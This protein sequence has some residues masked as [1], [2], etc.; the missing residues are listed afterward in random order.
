MAKP[1]LDAEKRRLDEGADLALP[2]DHHAQ[3]T[4]HDTADGDGRVLC[5]QGPAHGVAVAEREG[6][7]EIDAHQII[8]LGPQIGGGSQIIIVGGGLCLPDPAQDLLF[9]LGIDPYPELLFAADARLG[10]DKTVDILALPSGVRADIDG[11]HLG[12]SQDPLDDPELFLHAVDDLVAVLRRDKGNGRHGPLFEGGIIGVRIGHGDQVADAPGD[13]RVLRLHESVRIA[14]VFAE[15]SGKG[16]RHA[17][18]F[19]DIHCFRG[20]HLLPCLCR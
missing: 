14:E 15:G 18:L 4:G 1:A 10:G 19:R 7:G 12:V 13:D 9:R 8:L 6:P 20:A 16:A 11:V 2:P 3:D 17:G 5:P